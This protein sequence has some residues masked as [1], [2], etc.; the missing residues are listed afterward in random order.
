MVTKEQLQR[1]IAMILDDMRTDA[2]S[3]REYAIGALAALLWVLG[4]G[5]VLRP[6]CF[7]QACAAWD[8]M[9]AGGEVAP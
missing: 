7:A 9:R 1:E 4:G 3:Q 8:A 6:Q 2:E 5:D